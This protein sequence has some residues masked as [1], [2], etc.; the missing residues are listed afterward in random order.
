[1]K[2]KVREQLGQS[3]V[4]VIVGCFLKLM[5]NGRWNDLL[6][7]IVWQSPEDLPDTQRVPMTY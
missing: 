4:C 1:M 7:L 3:S 2:A 5:P 6:G